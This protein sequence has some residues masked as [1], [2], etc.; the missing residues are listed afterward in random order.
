MPEPRKKRAARKRSEEPSNWDLLKQ[1]IQDLNI[2]PN[3]KKVVLRLLETRHAGRIIYIRRNDVTR[4]E[5]E[6]AIKEMISS[7]MTLTEVRVALAKR[8]GFT[9][10]RAR[11][12]VSNALARKRPQIIK[13]SSQD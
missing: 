9:Q 5:R 13:P 12:L 10:A 7:S 4:E 6:R 1:D 2:N 8:F 11:Q 3:V